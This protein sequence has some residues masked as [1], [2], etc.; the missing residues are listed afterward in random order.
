MVAGAV[1]APRVDLLNQDMIRSHVHAVWLTSSGLKLGKTLAEILVVSEEDLSLPLREEILEKLASSQLRLKALERAKTVLGSLGTGLTS[2]YWYRDTWLDDIL[3]QIPQSFNAAC[4]R[5]RSL[6][7]AAVQ[8]RHLQNRIL[9]DHTRQQPDKERAKRLRGQA[10]DQINLLT[11][12][13]SAI[14]SDFYSYRYFASEGFLPGYNFPRLPL[15]AF[16]P[17]RRGRR[18][19]NEFLSRARFLAISEFGPRA[20][21]YHEGARYR[22]NKVNLAFDEGNQELTEYVM[23]RCSEC[24]G[25]YLEPVDTCVN[26]G[27]PFSA[28]DEVRNLVRLQNVTL[29]RADQ[30]TSDEEERQRVGYDIQTSYRFSEVAGVVDVRRAEVVLDGIAIATLCY[31][32]AAQIWRVNRGWRR[33]SRE[34]ELGFQLDLERGYWSSNR[35]E[36][37]NGDRED[38]QSPRVKRVV[39]FVEDH[40]NVL[41]INFGKFLSARVGSLELHNKLMATVQAALK[42]AIQQIYQL[43]PGEL[44]AEPLPDTT[45]RKLLFFFES[46]EGGAGVLRQLV[47]DPS[48]LPRI[49]Q[50]ALEI[51]HLDSQDGQDLAKKLGVQCEAACYDCLLE[52]GNQTEHNMIDRHLIGELLMQLVKSITRPSSDR[53]SRD[54][55]FDELL[56]HCDSDLERDWLRLLQSSNR[57]LPSHSQYL[58]RSANT[59]PDFFYADKRTAIYIDG[60]VHDMQ[61]TAQSDTEVQKRL[62]YAGIKWIRFSYKDDWEKILNE[63][64]DIFGKRF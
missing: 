41:T 51:C 33:R 44:A 50:A 27:L 57:S 6:Y 15:S 42:Q 5:W 29:K 18:G 62:D 10:E 56:K 2:A 52:Y 28:I 59:R 48:A 61:G 20:I 9:G 24:G 45:N 40:R 43:E 17:G 39:P 7:R 58:L 16:V 4:E 1:T 8:Q 30:I 63:Y 47:D 26:C 34:S 11:D 46:S 25:G 55:K 31:G 21:V 13:Q 36:I 64:P 53:L 22:V 60:P 35:E 14:E 37:E 19:R 49:A 54:E 12:S 32:D 38:P 23:K 3:H